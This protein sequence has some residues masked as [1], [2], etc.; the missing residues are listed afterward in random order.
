MTDL[1]TRRVANQHEPSAGDEL[2]VDR[3]LAFCRVGF[4]DAH[5]STGAHAHGKNQSSNLRAETKASCGISTLPML[6]I[7]F[8]PSF[9]FWRSLFFR[10]TSPP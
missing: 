6:F 1:R 3:Q 7:R 2:M 4:A 5:D 9:C 8:L 10:V